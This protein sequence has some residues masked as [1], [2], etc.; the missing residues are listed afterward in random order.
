MK[1]KFG[2]LLLFAGTV[3]TM[4]AQTPTVAQD[5]YTQ[6]GGEKVS[7]GET[8]I[9]SFGSWHAGSMDDKT[10]LLSP[11]F[12]QMIADN[13]TTLVGGVTAE[14]DGISVSWNSID[15]QIT[16]NCPSEKL[17]RTTV[18]IATMDGATR[19]LVNVDE[20]PAVISLADYTPGIYVAAVAV[21]GKLIKTFKINLK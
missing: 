5:I 20:S 19:G 4:S 1:L 14:A 11:L 17:G 8:V 12:E 18:L 9:Y 13:A 21:D 3:A 2:S 6:I 15:K 10:L 16:V 7:S